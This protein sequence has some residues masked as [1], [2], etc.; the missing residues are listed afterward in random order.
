MASAGLET[1]PSPGYPVNP[2]TG[3]FLADH[4]FGRLERRLRLGGRLKLGAGPE[5]PAE[6][7]LTPTGTW[8][9]ACDGRFVGEAVDATDPTKVRYHAG[10]LS[11]RIGV[12]E[13]TLSVPPGRAREARR[14]IAL[15][16]LRRQRVGNEPATLPLGGDR[17]LTDDGE[18]ARELVAA[19]VAAP[20]Q[21]ISMVEL[22]RGR[23][24]SVL[25]A[26]V[27]T[28]NYFVLSCEAAWFAELGEL[29]DVTRDEL[30]SHSLCLEAKSDA[31]LLTDGKRS[32]AV[33]SKRRT[34]VQELVEL[35]QHSAAERAS[36]A[37]RR[38]HVSGRA[39]RARTLLSEAGRRGDAQAT[40]LG[41]AL[42]LEL[43]ASH[44]PRD[45]FVAA[46][47]R[48]KEGAITGDACGETFRRWRFRPAVARDVVH[49]LT[50]LGP[51]AE[52][53]ALALHRASRA[54]ALADEK[55]RDEELIRA[56]VELSEHELSAG[57]GPR[58]RT[59]A[60][61]RLRA[62]GLDD[63]A[64]DATPESAQLH[65]ARLRLYEV[66]CREARARGVDDVASL[67]ALVRLEPLSEPRLRAL[68]NANGSDPRARR[69][70]ARAARVLAALS[71]GGLSQPC[72][73]LPTD[74]RAPFDRSTLDQRLRHPLAR[75]SGRFATRLSELVAA[76]PEPDLGF[77]RDFCEELS[78]TRHADAT[79]ALTRAAYLLGLPSVNAY[80]SHGARSVGLRAFG[81]NEPFV[82]IGKRHLTAGDEY[83][84]AGGELDFALGA[85][86]AHISF[87]H[88]RVTAGEVWAGAA[89]K[90]KDA[91]VALG[92]V[93]P[94]VA[95]L[96]GPRVQRILGRLGTEAFERATRGALRLPELFAARAATRGEPLGQRNEELIV[97]HRLVQLS[98]DRAGLAIAR[99]L[100]SAL[101]AMLLTRSDYRELVSLATT[102]GLTH[103][104]ESRQGGSPAVA[105]LMV[106]VR[107]VIGFY[108]SPEFDAVVGDVD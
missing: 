80:V 89:G 10:S 102:S 9:V 38:L 91:L 13:Q 100:C 81:S 56:D 78:E 15:G 35:A 107:A 90:T 40:L 101:R 14:L 62:L 32:C 6:L 11:D 68:A 96:G 31:T 19:L 37:A 64:V 72:P 106:R 73:P 87:G 69:A 57:E 66:L 46:V 17:Y 70:V 61:A 26:E 47:A 82:L 53:W 50:L 27:D 44:V 30:D 99:D 43:G 93:L 16:H 25:G 51:D 94:V 55:T 76:V 23:R 24:T 18:V 83:G 49:A 77:L 1:V 8:L 98:A 45:E 2:E 4:G 74:T 75:G 97:A 86:L 79:R 103:A 36:E 12:G 52:P 85:E 41:I 63:D 84:L 67:A 71:P 34:L 39:P 3:D 54:E 33:P 22:E 92:F 21:L 104:L 42:D 5:Q 58:A 105:D 48:L 29:G 95:D 88:Q 28:L 108:L 65:L 59:L 20:D 7:C 60:E